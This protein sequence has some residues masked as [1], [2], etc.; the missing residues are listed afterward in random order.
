M[1][2]AVQANADP[3]TMIGGGPVMQLLQERLSLVAKTDA[4]VLITGESGVGKELAAR[5]IH[6]QSSRSSKQFVTVNCASMPD[7]L[8]ES[9][10]FG[11]AKGAF[12]GAVS[13]RI[14]RFQYA[15]GGTLFLD[16]VAEIP[17]E[18]QGKLLRVV[19]YSQFEPIGED[20]TR[21]VDVRVLAATNTDLPDAVEAGRFRR[22]L[23]Y[24]LNVFP[25]D[26]PPLRSRKEDIAPLARHFLESAAARLDRPGMALTEQHLDMLLDYDWPGNVRELKSIIERAVILSQ[27]KLRLD[28]SFSEHAL[29][30]FSAK[31][32]FRVVNNTTHRVV[33]TAAQM[34]EL[35]RENTIAALEQADWRISGDGGAAA[36]LGVPPSTLSSKMKAMQILRPEPHA[37]Y[38]RIGGYEGIAAFVN[39]LMPMLRSDHRLS[40]FWAHR[41]EDGIRS[42]KQQLVFVFLPGHRRSSE[43]HWP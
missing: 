17:V 16:E 39:D 19:Q 41:G 5:L 43:L 13:E 15:D 9:E 20:S 24:R 14:G 32:N 30:R 18:L 23:Y 29:R 7:G 10:F 37:L 28:L 22:D 21:Q 11:H 12:T 25:I 8:F 2:K 42:E 26:V 34:V 40:R 35:E 36:L 38:V 27:R 6:Q 4:T 3:V 33:L 1:L 31:D